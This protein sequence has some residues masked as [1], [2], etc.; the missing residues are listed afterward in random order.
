MLPV[1]YFDFISPFAYLQFEWLQRERPDF[2]FEP[3]PVL[4]AALLGHWGSVGPAELLTKRVFTYRFVQWQARR[5][6]IAMRFPP[7]HPFNPLAALRLCIAAGQSTDAIGAIFRH[8]WCDGHAGDSAQAL[9]P[10]AAALGIDDAAAAISDPAVKATLAR[11]GEAAIADGVFG[12]PTFAVDGR[13]F[14][15]MDATPMLFDWLQDR[16]GFEDE[17]MRALEALPVGVER[18]R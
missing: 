1:W 16:D 13:L 14:W 6:G 15:G 5:Q 2:R 10:V 7:A 17:A 8:I 11:N 3:R 4:F 9:A 12:V 18:P